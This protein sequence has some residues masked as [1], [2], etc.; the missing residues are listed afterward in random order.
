MRPLIGVA[1]SAFYYSHADTLFDDVSREV[2]ETCWQRL[3][4]TGKMCAHIESAGGTAVL[5][6]LKEDAD[7][8]DTIAER[9]D[10]F[11][12]A[13]GAD[14]TPA[15]YGETPDGSGETDAA[16]DKFEYALL[17]KAYQKGKTVFGICRG[18]QMMNIVFGGTIF[19]D[20]NSIDPTW[21]LHQG[22]YPMEDYIHSVKALRP[23]FLPRADGT[24]ATALDVN[25]AHHQAIKKLAPGFV[26]TA[27]TDDGLI[28]GIAL[29]EYKKGLIGVQWHPESLADKDPVQHD[30]FRMLVEYAGK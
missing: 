1:S 29:P 7:V 4:L 13:G 12:F 16:R 15:L 21:K 18:Q 8:I 10:G 25:S 28:E 17:K 5:L 19:Q 27:E 23:E 11:L 3:C 20:I 9:F 2:I 14:I 30:F 6:S 22:P 24:Y 26:V